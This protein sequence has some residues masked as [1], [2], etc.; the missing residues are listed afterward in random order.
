MPNPRVALH[1][2]PQI[3]AT[4]DQ[5]AKLMGVATSRFIATLLI[6]SEP[7]IKAMQKPLEQALTGKQEAL[8]GMSDLMD[9]IKEQ[10]DEH[11][12]ELL[13]KWHKDTGKS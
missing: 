2:P 11:Q 8:K 6:E 7:S 1:L 4:Y 12:Y 13:Q 3:K 5:T 10:A 9:D